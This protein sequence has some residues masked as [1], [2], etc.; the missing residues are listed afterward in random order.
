MT[1][2]TAWL[3]LISPSHPFFFAGLLDDM[4]DVTLRTTVRRKTETV[5]LAREAGFDFQTMG[6][7]F[8]NV[9]LRTAAVPLRTIQASVQAPTADVSLSARNAMCVLASR[10]RRLPSIHFTDNDI[11]AY[12]DAPLVERAFC[13]FR[14]TATHHVVPSAFR[15]SELTRWGADPERI[16]TYDG[17]KEDVY[18]ASFEPDETFPER[19]PFDT[20]VVL[21]PEALG[22][23]YVDEGQSLVPHLLEALDA[24]GTNVVYLPRRQGDRAYADPYPEDRVYVPDGALDGLQLAWHSDGVLTGSGTMAREAACMGKPAVS[25]F[26]GPLLSVDR[27]MVEE[28]MIV[29]SRDPDEMVSYLESVGTT[30]RTPD[31]SRCFE[32]REEASSLVRALIE[33]P[34]NPA[35][36]SYPSRSNDWA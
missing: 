16:H 10:A 30:D 35:L 23:A 15:T 7:D 28:G 20:F 13:R 21:R 25:F 3:D 34:E 36:G 4:E 18:V 5:D 11:T 31:R 9:A 33:N 2:V 32:V 8:E 14:S 22:A 12:I 17:Y 24:T 26:P 1:E 29:H 19:L 6:R 27:S